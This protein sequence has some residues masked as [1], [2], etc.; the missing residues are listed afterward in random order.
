MSDDPPLTCSV[1]TRTVPPGCVDN[2]SRELRSGGGQGALGVL[3]DDVAHQHPD[4][5]RTA[6]RVEAAAGGSARGPRR[7]RRRA[8]SARA[9]LSSDRPPTN[10]GL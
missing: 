7:R 10:G 1:A 3:G 4:R 8:R 6:E 9:P 5:P 2:R